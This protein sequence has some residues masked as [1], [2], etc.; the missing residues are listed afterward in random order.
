M[1]G[2]ESDGKNLRA[3]GLEN[4]KIPVLCSLWDIY[5]LRKLKKNPLDG[6]I[7]IISLGREFVLFMV[8]RF[9]VLKVFIKRSFFFKKNLGNSRENHTGCFSEVRVSQAENKVRSCTDPF[10][11]HV[12]R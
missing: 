11:S 7:S 10:V 12:L 5:H 1:L 2:R 6:W 8:S 4:T 3:P 9:W